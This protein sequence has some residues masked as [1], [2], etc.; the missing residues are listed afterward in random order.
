MDET[1]RNKGKEKKK[2]RSFEIIVLTLESRKELS[3]F[4]RYFEIPSSC[5]KNIPYEILIILN[6]FELNIQKNPHFDVE[7]F[8]FNFPS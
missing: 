7:Y 5:Y 2:S 4:R 8:K 3:H 1:E 6:L